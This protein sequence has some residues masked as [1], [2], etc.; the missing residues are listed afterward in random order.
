MNADY[1]IEKLKERVLEAP[2]SK[3]FLT[4]AEELRKRGEDE[5]A[6]MV[7]KD[8]IGKNPSFVAARL[9]LGRWYLREN[10]LDEAK[11]ELLAVTDYAPG[12]R[13]ALRYL[14]DIETRL[15]AEGGS[16][17]QKTVDRLTRFREAIHSRF[18]SESLSEKRAGDR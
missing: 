4:L 18:G 16:S 6:F 5:E 9:T 17:I 1:F 13:F 12:D 3:L 10:R 2:E 8:G 15:K 7:L 14:G 11:R